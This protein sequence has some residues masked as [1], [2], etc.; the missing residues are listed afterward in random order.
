[1]SHHRLHSWVLGIA[2]V[3]SAGVCIAGE[4]LD[5]A[6]DQVRHETGGKVLSA[7]TVE[8]NGYRVRRIKVLVDGRVRIYDIPA[9]DDDQ[10]SH[11]RDRN[12]DP[13]TQRPFVNRPGLSNPERRGARGSVD[14]RPPRPMA[15]AQNRSLEQGE[16]Q[17]QDQDQNQGSNQNQDQKPAQDSDAQSRRRGPN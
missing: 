3:T 16:K 8:I 6:V 9:G 12:G 7:Q 13:E 2:L 11:S 14:Q 17:V 4:S 5:D 15:P 1:M 10:G